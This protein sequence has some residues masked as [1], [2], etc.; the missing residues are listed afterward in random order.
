MLF[1]SQSQY[2]D[3]SWQ[4]LA[5]K[6]TELN[7]W[8]SLKKAIAYRPIQDEIA[9]SKAYKAR[10]AN[11]D[12][13]KKILSSFYNPPEDEEDEPEKEIDE[14]VEAKPNGTKTEPEKKVKVDEKKD[15]V[16]TKEEVKL[17]ETKTNEATSSKS[18]KEAGQEKHKKDKKKK[19]NKNI[20]ESLTDERLTAYGIN[21]KKFKKKLKYSKPDSSQ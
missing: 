3:W 16:K 19:K 17:Q 5:C 6:D 20:L 9:D 13:K 21:P 8:A 7:N 2:I 18:V 10:K 4:I 14:K 1:I 12:L 11:V 15:T